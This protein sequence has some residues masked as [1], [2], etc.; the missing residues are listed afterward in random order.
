MYGSYGFR[1]SNL[2]VLDQVIQT[3]R[4]S[5]RNRPAAW[6]R[7]NSHGLQTIADPNPDLISGFYAVRRF[8]RMAVDR[9]QARIA[10]PLCQGTAQTKTTGF[11]EKIE[12][13]KRES[14][15]PPPQ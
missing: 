1:L 7:D 3:D 6:Y 10:K 2:F 8:C 9:H 15:R 5:F 14:G 11:K 12:A 4:F 13:H